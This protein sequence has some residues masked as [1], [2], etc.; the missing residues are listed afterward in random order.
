MVS[1]WTLSGP[2]SDYRLY[3]FSHS[4]KA[5]ARDREAL[6][7]GERITDIRQAGMK[8]LKV[9]RAEPEQMRRRVRGSTG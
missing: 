2:E 3:Y 5:M 8:M 9:E 6:I 1:T 7:R 4:F